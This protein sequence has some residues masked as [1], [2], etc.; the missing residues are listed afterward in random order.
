MDNWP[1]ALAGLAVDWTLAI[2]KNRKTINRRPILEADNSGR[3]GHKSPFHEISRKINDVLV[4]W[5]CQTTAS[6]FPNPND[7]R[8]ALCC[9][10]FPYMLRSQ[11]SAG[12]QQEKSILE[13]DSACCSAVFSR[14]RPGT[15]CQ[16]NHL[17]ITQLQF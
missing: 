12:L 14:M 13:A 4:Q 5:L 15:V 8:D 2:V 1:E 17:I 7:T 11:S 6:Q 16:Q 3:L 10:C 9:H